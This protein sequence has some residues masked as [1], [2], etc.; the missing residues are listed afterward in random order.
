MTNSLSE[1]T[2]Q[3][4]LDLP[5]P[6]LSYSRWVGQCSSCALEYYLPPF[7]PSPHRHLSHQKSTQTLNIPRKTSSKMANLHSVKDF[8]KAKRKTLCFCFWVFI[9]DI[10]SHG[11]VHF[12]SWWAVRT[13]LAKFILRRLAF[14]VTSKDCLWIGGETAAQCILGRWVDFSE[15]IAR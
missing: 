12:V 1:I 14:E 7:F 10:W 9:S 5:V 8:M 4:S 3:Y 11:S 2:M 6:A 13:R 15:V